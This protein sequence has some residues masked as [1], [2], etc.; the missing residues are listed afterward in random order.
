MYK[1]Y[2]EGKTWSDADAHCQT[3]GGHLASVQSVVDQEE[4][5]AVMGK[6]GAVWIGASDRDSEGDWRWSDGS[7]WAYE[8]WG[9][10]YGNKGDGSNCVYITNEAQ[11]YVW[12]DYLCTFTFRFLCL[13]PPA[14][15]LKGQQTHTLEYKK[16]NLTFPT[17]NVLY[18]YTANQE[19]LNTWEDKRMTGFKLSWFLKDSNDSRLTET[20]KITAD[21]KPEAPS[22]GYQEPQMVSM[23]KLATQARTQNLSWE[24][25]INRTILEKTKLITNRQLDYVSMCSEGQIKPNNNNVISRL[26]IGVNHTTGGVTNDEDILNGFKLFSTLVYCSES[27]ALSQFLHSLLSSHSPR[28]II[29]ATVNTIQSGDVKEKSNRK[30]MGQFYFALDKIFHFQHGKILLA[31]ASQSDIE[32]MMTKDWPYFTHYSQEIEECFNNASCQ[33]VRDLVQTLGKLLHSDFTIY[34]PGSDGKPNEVSFHAPH[35]IDSSGSLTPAALIPFCSYKANMDMLGKTKDS[36]NFTACSQFKPTV[37][38]GQLCY[39]VG[40]K[41]SIVLWNSDSD[42]TG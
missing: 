1:L 40:K 28:T 31:T 21:W 4:A 22:P 10:N 7:H 35:L 25:V 15:V 20:Q 9:A 30:R 11:G 26:T 33:G 34:S 2:T 23:I 18:R 41:V 5:R 19:L 42:I 6:N 29:K 8:N 14:V 38:E 36:L 13:F 16:Q 37:L 17:I 3:E 24:E 32:A 39:R 12:R 27:V